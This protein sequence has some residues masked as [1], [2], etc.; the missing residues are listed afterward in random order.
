[1]VIIY[2]PGTATAVSP[3]AG[4]T[5]GLHSTSST[6]IVGSPMARVYAQHRGLRRAM[7]QLTYLVPAAILCLLTYRVPAATLTECMHNTTST[8]ARSTA[9]S[10]T[11][12]TTSI[13]AT[14]TTTTAT[15]AVACSVSML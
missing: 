6:W 1:M 2:R 3:V 12:M 15:A 9:S 11:L 13:A 4:A 7:C 5:T 8:S 14:T 10:T